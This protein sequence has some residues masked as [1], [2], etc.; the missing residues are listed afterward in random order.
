[1][2]EAATSSPLRRLR[3]WLIWLVAVYIGWFT[4]V[5]ALG[6]WERLSE[7]WHIA[8]AM[9]AGSY[10]A[11]STPM[12]GGTVGFPI[13]VLLF[14]QPASLGRNFSFL[15]QS[16]GM[17]S[18][19]IFILCR[20]GPIAWRVLLWAMLGSLLFL[21]AYS[22]WL[23]PLVGDVVVKLVF[24]CVWAAFGVMSLVKLREITTAA[25]AG[26]HSPRADA[27]AGLLVAAVGCV[28]AALTGVGV[29]MVIYSALVLLYRCEVRRAVATSV[30][31]MA[32]NSLLG[33]ACSASLGRINEEA[34]VN[35]LAAA[36]VVALGAPLGA[37]MLNIIP[38]GKTLVFVS[39]LCLLQ[40]GWTLAHERITGATLVASLAAL[41][42]INAA[43]HLVHTLGDRLQRRRA[44]R[45]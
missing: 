16:I 3:V 8:A 37:F 25:G 38:R 32:F 36:P 40:F 26:A 12:G 30:L 19:S 20:K 1:M 18:A 43:F 45:A 39:I 23:T 27:L 2:A 10:V 31:L 6:W 35:W 41:L 21:P 22:L 33:A 34:V 28:P 13:L 24:A 14:D 11:G 42:A 17:T 15:I 29:D 9:L 4:L 44:G 5:T 7:H